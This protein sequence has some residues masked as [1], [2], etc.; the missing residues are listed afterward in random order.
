VADS[1]RDDF[2]GHHSFYSSEVK[3]K[4]VNQVAVAFAQ[5]V[6]NSYSWFH[7]AQLLRRLISGASHGPA[8]PQPAPPDRLRLR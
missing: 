6:A 2:E 1:Q 7:C 3:R 5:R 8:P 4:H